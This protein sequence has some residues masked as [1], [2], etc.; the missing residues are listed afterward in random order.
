[1]Q[2]SD[3]TAAPSRTPAAT[4]SVARDTTGRIGWRPEATAI[5]VGAAVSSFFALLV[6]GGVLWRYLSP[7]TFQSGLLLGGP[8]SPDF[9]AFVLRAVFHA[10]VLA[11]AVAAFA[12]NGRVAR[13]LLLAGALGVV[14]VGLYHFVRVNLFPYS[15][16]ARR[17]PDVLFNVLDT[18]V[19]FIDMGIPH[20]LLALAI[21]RPVTA[22]RIPSDKAPAAL[23]PAAPG[24][25][26]VEG[27]R[28]VPAQPLPYS[29]YGEEKSVDAR[30]VV[31]AAGVAA[32]GSLARF[33]MLACVAALPSGFQTIGVNWS[34]FTWIT[35]VYV[36]TDAGLLVGAAA[37]LFGR[38]W[39]RPVLLAAAWMHLA[40]R[41][42]SSTVGR[43]RRAACPG[44]RGRNWQCHSPPTSPGSSRRRR[45]TR[46]CST[47][48]AA[49][50]GP[51]LPLPPAEG[52]GEGGVRSERAAGGTVRTRTA[53]VDKKV[54]P[55]AGR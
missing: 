43:I 31:L 30:A 13:K 2:H 45:C 3:S 26:G 33:A 51:S 18:G 14:A 52:C 44:T 7:K 47:S 19:R 12:G 23:M 40:L 27:H 1:M 29:Q 50:A 38:R 4:G 36:L 42:A 55:P 28:V 41:T 9:I 49:L 20:M 5:V 15:A 53:K 37:A 8:L 39:A 32:L 25:A 34:D 16:G 48:C 11:G 22:F 46:C 54:P 21:M 10:T 6:W 17:G 35:P 24:E